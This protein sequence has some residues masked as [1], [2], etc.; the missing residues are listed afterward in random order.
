MSIK[1]KF[2]NTS[3]KTNNI[4][5][6]ITIIIWTFI[7][8]ILINSASSGLMPSLSIYMAF[9]ILILL[10]FIGILF[11]II[12]MAVATATDVPFHSMAAKNIKGTS[13]AIRLIKNS[14]KVA[15]FCNDV[16]GDISG[17]ISGSAAAIIV[18][19]IAHSTVQTTIISL[20]ITAVVAALTVGG[21]AFGKGLA[22]RRANAIVY[23][24]A[25]ILYYFE[26]I[27]KRKGKR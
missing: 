11:D 25:L 18:S 8:S 4:K 12:G 1:I 5:W 22:M 2:K 10:I 19:R 3:N 21:K 26:K 23:R 24:V 17:I 13:Q 15:S 9:I 20:L 16:V 27:F 14:E 7:L 6:I